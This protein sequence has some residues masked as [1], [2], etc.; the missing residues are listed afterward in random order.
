MTELDQI[1]S[2]MLIDAGQRAS[3]TGSQ[4]IAE[5]LRLKATNDAIRTA[6]VGWLFDTVLEIAG[7]EMGRRHGVNIER[8]EPHRFDRGS[9]IM[10][11]S[12]IRINHGVRCMTVEAGWARTPSDGIMRK[13]ALAF[14][15]IAHFG[16]PKVGAEMRLVRAEPMPEWFDEDG[17]IVSSAMIESHIDKLFDR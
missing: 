11:G 10:V 9:S 14:A 3:D 13:G 12:L 8:E 15:R 5:Y 4:E 1:W 2:K 6:G 17:G 7:R 16:M